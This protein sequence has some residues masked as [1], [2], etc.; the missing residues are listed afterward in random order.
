MCLQ[1]RLRLGRVI[2]IHFTLLCLLHLK[3]RSGFHLFLPF[4]VILFFLGF[5]PQCFP[6][7]CWLRLLA[8]PLQCLLP[9]IFLLSR[10]LPLQVLVWALWWLQVLWCKILMIVVFIPF[11]TFST[12]GSG[13]PRGGGGG[14]GSLSS[15]LRRALFFVEGSQ[16]QFCCPVVPGLANSL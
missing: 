10:F 16:W 9:S 11:C 15:A 4:L 14:G 8:L 5:C 1:F 12:A 6:V 13:Y 7:L 3:L 2:L